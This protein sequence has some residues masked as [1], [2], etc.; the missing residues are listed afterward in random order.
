MAAF[1][2]QAIC[3]AFYCA[4]TAS[5]PSLTGRDAALYGMLRPTSSPPPEPQGLLRYILPL[6]RAKNYKNIDTTTF[7]DY[8]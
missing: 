3:S 1:E 8:L 2:N 4:V 7:I 5:Q 6:L